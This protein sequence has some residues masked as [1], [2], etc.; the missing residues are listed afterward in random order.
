M[1][2]IFLTGAISALSV[3]LVTASSTSTEAQSRRGLMMTT[4]AYCPM[5]TCSPIGGRF[6][7]HVKYC[8]A[9]NCAGA[10]AKRKR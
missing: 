8:K 6:A 2:A 10:A 9:S 1:K 5:G 7:Y 3:F 4:G